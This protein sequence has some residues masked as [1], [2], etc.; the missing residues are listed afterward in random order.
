M[1]T[2]EEISILLKQRDIVRYIEI[3]RL[4]WLGHLERIHEETTT[5]QISYIYIY[6]N[7][8]MQQ[9]IVNILHNMFRPQSAILRCF[10]TMNKYNK[11]LHVT[12]FIYIADLCKCNR[13]LRYRKQS[14]YFAGSRHY[15]ELKDG[16]R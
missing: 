12:V 5:K 13:M 6:K 10:S 15:P 14:K 8:H 4:E 9:F 3:Q 7:R 2:N 1:T 11:L 16:K